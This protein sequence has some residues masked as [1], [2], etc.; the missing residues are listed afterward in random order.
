MKKTKR[1]EKSAPR[2]KASTAGAAGTPWWYYA[3]GLTAVLGIAL[4]VYGPALNGPFLFDDLYLTMNNPGISADINRWLVKIRP[5][6]TLSFWVN[7]SV[8]GHETFSYHVFNVFFHVINTF[9]IFA[10]LRRLL[11]LAGSTSAWIAGFCAGVFLLH[12]VQTESV[13]YIAGR[14]ESFS[15]L[16]FLAAFAVFLYRRAGE[17]T[18]PVSAS[19]LLLF[20]AAL[21]SKEH[22][23]VLPGLLLL[24]DYYLSPPGQALSTIRKNWRLYVPIA[25]G[26]IA[27]VVVILRSID[28]SSSAGF[29]LK[30]ATWYEYLFT[31]FRVFFVYLRLFLFP[32]N[33]TIDYDFPF[34]RSLVDHGAIFG[35]IGILALL[36]AAVVWRRRY[37]LASM[38][39]LAFGLL[40]L[41]TSSIVPIK[42]PLAERRLYLPMI[43]LLLIL[44]EILL[45]WNP[46]RRTLAAAGGAVLVIL[47][48]AT[49]QR[50]RVWSDALLAWEDTVAKSPNKARAH[51]QL[52]FAYYKAGRCREALPHYE[53]VSKLQA[54]DDQLLIDWALAYDCVNQPEQALA[55]LRQATE[56]QKKSAHAWALMGMVYGKSGRA[57]EARESIDRAIAVNPNFDL[58]YVYL[59]HLLMAGQDYAGASRQYRK[60]LQLNPANQAAREAL[61]QIP[62][63]LR[64]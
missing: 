54:P 24:T 61:E 1:A 58:S 34:S 22:T 13:A 25:V 35:L 41:P 38:G 51:F 29:G 10:V 40:L 17:V 63:N 46:P 33:L 62:Q 7:Y 30:D 12:P 39:L 31:Q 48:A 8:S 44:A 57:P 59:G 5:L 37:P 55:K 50:S 9:L 23:I 6:L 19:I 52:A 21:A 47:A 16:F 36:A 60:A 64:N 43:G 3:V 45:R 27:G 42:D 2:A 26:G 32:V 4:Q 15:V 49:Y 28:W 20:A 14:S 11:R 53:L 56:V 18:W